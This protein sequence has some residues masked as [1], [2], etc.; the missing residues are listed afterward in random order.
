MIFTIFLPSQI[1]RR[2][3][4][5]KDFMQ[6]MTNRLAMG[7]YRYGEP[8]ASKGYLTR[9]EAELKAYKRIGNCEQ[10][11]NIANYCWLESV[12]PENEKFHFDNRVKSV[13]RKKE[14]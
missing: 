14:N 3:E 1:Q 13:T 2:A 9:M 4:P 5:I 7:H 8:Q 12:A 6:K 11:Y 10:L